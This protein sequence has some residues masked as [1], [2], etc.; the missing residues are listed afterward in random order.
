VDVAL[1]AATRARASTARFV[2]GDFSTVDIESF[3]GVYLFNP[4]E[5]NVWSS[6]ERLDDTVPMSLAKARADI[7]CA[8]EMLARAHR[9]TRVVTYHGFGGDIPASYKHLLSEPH[10]NGDLDLWIK[11]S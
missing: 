11:V 4:F 3:D 5:E 10:G 8:E 7:A 2:H 6:D 9:G 1:A